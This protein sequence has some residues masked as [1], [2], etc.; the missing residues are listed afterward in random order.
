MFET[1]PV[2]SNLKP[3]AV[4]RSIYVEQNSAV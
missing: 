2:D 3:R 4:G 1:H